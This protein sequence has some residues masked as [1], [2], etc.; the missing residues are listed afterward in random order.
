MVAHL[1]FFTFMTYFGKCAILFL[2]LKLVESSM[3]LEYLLIHKSIFT[4][5]FYIKLITLMIQ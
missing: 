5:T 3:Y 2:T 1:K 4:Y